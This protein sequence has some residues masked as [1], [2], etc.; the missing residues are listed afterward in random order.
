MIWLV[1]NNKNDWEASMKMIRCMLPMMLL[2]GAVPLTAFA[3]GTLAIN[4]APFTS[5]VKL[6]QKVQKQLEGGGMEWG[7]AGNHLVVT[8]LNKQYVGPTINQLTRF[9]TNATMSLPA[10]EYRVSCV[11]LLYEGGLSVAKVLSKGG[12]FN[13]N[14]MTFRIEDD[15]TTALDV[16][17]VIRTS[18]GMLIKVFMPEYLVKA[19]L[20]GTAAPEVSINARTDKSVAWDDYSGDLKF[21]K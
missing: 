9:G 12:Y 21:K 10:G 14:V 15:K 16:R 6:K 4:I 1:F 18:S 17:P 13:E 11:G 7:L 19:S 20:D 2:V 5:E 8:T 3:D